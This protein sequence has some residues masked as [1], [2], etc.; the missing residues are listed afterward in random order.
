MSGSIVQFSNGFETE[1]EDESTI[2]VLPNEIMLI[3]FKYLQN[4]TKLNILPYVCSRWRMICRTMI[5][6]LNISQLQTD[7]YHM[8]SMIEIM[9]N[10]K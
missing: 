3:I 9:L 6:E 4:A 1:D 7:I 2:F 5:F 10:K 8:F